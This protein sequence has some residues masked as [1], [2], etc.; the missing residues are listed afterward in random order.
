MLQAAY[1]KVSNLNTQ[2]EAKVFVLFDT[3]DKRSYISDELR[4]YLK[5]SVLLKERIFIKTFGKVEPTIKT[6]EIVQLKVSSPSKSVVIEATCTPF[7]CSDILSQNVHSNASSY[8]HVQNLT[9][10]DFS[11]NGNKRIHILVDEDC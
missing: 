2:K 10:V 3:G 6:V 1:T 9:I 11:P 5:R 4:N 8:G 7:I